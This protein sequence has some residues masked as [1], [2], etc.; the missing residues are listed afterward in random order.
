MAS[1]GWIH[2]SKTFKDHVNSILDMM[3]EEGIVDELGVGAFRDAFADIFFPGISTIQRRAK[4]FFIVPYLIA[5][6]FNLP[7]KQQTD[8]GRFLDETEHEIMWKLAAKYNFNRAGGS[9][10][11]GITK[12]P[13][14]R[15]ARRPTSI[16]W[17]G[18]RTMGFIK[19]NLSL[20]E[21][22]FRTNE[23]LEQK[24]TR[25]IAAKYED[26]D[27]VDI[28]LSDGHNV[29]VST[30]Q[31]DWNKDLD[32]PLSYEEA[33]YFQKQ[34]IR[35]VPRSLLGQIIVNKNLRKLFIKHKEFDLFT[36]AILNETLDSELK[37]TIILAHDLN[38]V[39]KGLHWV[40]CNEINHLYYKF[41]DYLEKWSTWEYELF[42]NLIDPDN[43]SFE[44]IG[45]IAPRASY[46]SKEFIRKV[47]EMI[48]SKNINYPELSALV[49]EQERNI[50]GPK[51]RFRTGAEVDFKKGERRSLSYLN[52]RYKNAKTIITDIIN[53]L[54]E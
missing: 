33:D 34:I 23:T 17:N 10:V 7:T 21:Y 39:V 52:Y 47:L 37:S 31:S 29:K 26:S 54:K 36:K 2:F 1:L 43:L 50:K 18:L 9:G 28:D 40:Y 14:T 32:L 35:T 51:S 20:S 27:D 12:R 46:Y 25:N 49:I 5:D 15:I 6:Y 44:R 13:R 41:D 11:I 48:N 53:G 19:T 45:M 38:E 8:L 3:D 16:Y 22:V 42:Q 30:Y 24:L 4:Y